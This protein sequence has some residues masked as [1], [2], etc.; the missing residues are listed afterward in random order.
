MEVCTAP[1]KHENRG[2]LLLVARDEARP[3]ER[4]VVRSE[5]RRLSLRSLI[6]RGGHQLRDDPAGFL[7]Q[8]IHRILRAVRCVHPLDADVYRVVRSVAKVLN[9]MMKRWI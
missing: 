3:V 4:N 9:A 6:V 7:I 1:E 5:S 8:S 2:R